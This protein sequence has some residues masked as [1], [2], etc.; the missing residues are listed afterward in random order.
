M[1]P[2]PGILSEWPWRPL[3][4]FKYLLLAPFAVHS[5]YSFMTKG[6]EERDLFEFLIFPFM[7]WRVLHNQ[8][9]I[10]VSQYITAKGTKRIVD[11]GVNF[12]L[13]DFE[14][15]W[16]DEIML[17]GIAFYVLNK[18]MLYFGGSPFPLWRKGVVIVT[19]LLHIGSLEFTHY[20]WHRLMHLPYFYIRYHYHHHAFIASE[21]NNASVTAFLEVASFYMIFG[22]PLL[23]MVL[24]GTGSIIVI[25]GYITLFEFL[26]GAGHSNFEVT[27]KW[28]FSK[29]RPFM[30]T[31]S[32]HAL[33]HTQFWTNYSLFLPF[34]DYIYGTYDKSSDI[35]YE[36]SVKRPEESP[37]VVHLTHLTTADSSTICG[38]GFLHWLL[39]P[40]L[41]NERNTLKKLKL[42]SWVVPRYNKQYFSQKQRGDINKLIEDAILEADK[43]GAKAFSLGLMNQQ[44][45]LN[46]NGELYTQRHPQLKFKVVDG[47]SL[48]AA[49]VLNSIPAETTQVILR[50]KLDRVAYAIASALCQKGIQVVTLRENEFEKLKHIDKSK[51]DVVLSHTFDQKVWLVGN[52]LTEKE[53]LKASKGTIFI[54]F[55]QYPPKEVRKD[56]YY[57]TTPSMMAPKSFQNLHSCENW[58]PRRAIS[59]S[60]VAGIVHALEGWDVHDCGTNMLGIDKVWDASLQ[61]GFLPLPIPV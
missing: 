7:L 42:Q 11:R 44:E 45:D 19:I 48:A 61:H 13:V 10:S 9:W 22:I 34:Y 47:S 58:L 20:W 18:M 55:S 17:N 46:R 39:S 60:R 51:S 28:L 25:Y 26:N 30:F 12:E 59:A 1:A 3:G 49:V 38:L 4:N 6:K 27:P 43:K 52:G 40:N 36:T 53:Q 2:K 15:N 50:G 54:P 23:G 41:L 29:F 14:S 35:I 33:H 16:D 32:F 31:S 5:T 57:H 21:S 24:T 8:M 56:C 37:D